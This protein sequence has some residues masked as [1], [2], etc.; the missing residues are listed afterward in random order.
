MATIHLFN[1]DHDLA[2][3]YGRE[4]FTPP[5]AGRGMRKGLGYIPAFWAAEGD[6]V[7]VDD[8]ET[9]KR[10]VGVLEDLLPSV[11]ILS[12]EGLAAA[13]R[14][15]EF[16]P[17]KV[18]PWG[19]NAALCFRL[20]RMGV[21][22]GL[23]PSQDK[24]EHIRNL[25]HR[26]ATIALLRQLVADVPMTI[27]ERQEAF[28]L[29]DVRSWL[30]DKGASVVKSPWSSSGR[31]VRFLSCDMDANFEG[32]IRN[33]MA[34]QGSVLLEPMYDKVMDFAMEFD[35]D[36]MG[37]ARYAGLSL[38]ETQHGAYFGNLLASEDEKMLRMG[39]LVSTDVLEQVKKVLETR[40]GQM[41]QDVYEG[42]LGVDMMVVRGEKGMLVHPCVE[43]NVRRTMG[44]VALC[45]ARRV[46]GRF[47]IMRVVCDA[48]GY[49]MVF[50]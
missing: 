40:L 17:K 21:Q 47:S 19:W 27:G 25:S 29:D 15:G 9:A 50:E 11:T 44:H 2:L 3:A 28:S 7:V 33:T 4:G 39:A 5:A 30:L 38:F 34:K 48:M 41:C 12:P 45:V 35:A 23:M 24:L 16:L 20:R 13:I 32:F 14:Q 42:P 26:K 18:M 31:G 10:A 46:K 22:V 1:P 8:V 6:V 49:R 43:V 37:M 36:G